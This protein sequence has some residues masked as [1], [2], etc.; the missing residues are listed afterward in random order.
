MLSRS[1]DPTIALTL[2]GTQ[3]ACQEQARWPGMVVHVTHLVLRVEDS[4]RQAV[5]TL[6]FLTT[7]SRDEYGRDCTALEVARQR[8]RL[9]DNP[10]TVL[11]YTI[12]KVFLQ[13]IPTQVSSLLRG[14][15]NRNKI[16]L[17]LL[18]TESK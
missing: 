2:R 11:A 17:F 10:R 5:G 3:L 12:L 1:P 15:S 14:C 7:I 9:K 13:S 16:Y 4:P 6:S 8:H 18:P